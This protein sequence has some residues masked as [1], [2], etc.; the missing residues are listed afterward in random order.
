[1]NTKVTIG[2]I[3]AL[4]SADAEKIFCHKK[5]KLQWLTQ[6]ITQNVSWLC[7]SLIALF[8]SHYKYSLLVQYKNIY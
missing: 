5:L 8:I 6:F 1:M 2:Y 4:A 7:T 3:V